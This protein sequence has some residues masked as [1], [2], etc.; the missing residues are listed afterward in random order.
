MNR[1]EKDQQVRKVHRKEASKN[2]ERPSFRET[3]EVKYHG[4]S[5]AGKRIDELL[6]IRS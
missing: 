5:R 3:G 6:K 1:L 2:R 4:L